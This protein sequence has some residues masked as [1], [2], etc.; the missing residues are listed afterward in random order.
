MK[1]TQNALLVGLFFIQ[2][3]SVNCMNRFAQKYLTNSWWVIWDSCINILTDI[4]KCKGLSCQSKTKLW[5]VLSCQRKTKIC[6]ALSRFNWNMVLY[7]QIIVQL[8]HKICLASSI[9]MNTCPV[10][11]EAIIS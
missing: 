5:K 3:Q 6:L 11:F 10:L 8:C 4:L 7:Y 1:H 2:K 9:P